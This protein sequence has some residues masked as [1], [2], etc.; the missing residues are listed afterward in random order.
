MGVLCVS[1]HE[2]RGALVI[3]F[4]IFWSGWDWGDPTA[5]LGSGRWR[6]SFVRTDAADPGV[7]FG[8]SALGTGRILRLL[9]QLE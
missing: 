7:G 9:E 2:A 4:G 6:E 1:V 8:V 5:R 3:S